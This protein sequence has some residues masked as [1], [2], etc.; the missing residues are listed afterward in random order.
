[1][2]FGNKNSKATSEITMS[3]N[4]ELFTDLFEK[5][6][7]VSRKCL[8]CAESGDFEQINFLVEQRD[9]LI[10]ITETIHERLTLEQMNMDSSIA[11]E[12]NNQVNE[13]IEKMNQMDE[14]I[15]IKLNEERDNMQIE[16]AKSFKN[17]ENFRGYN[18]N[19]LK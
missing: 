14:Q 18:L 9:K 4:Y 15:L 12:F 19:C 7:Y 1:M 13:L 8:E 17:K 3:K 5:I 6:I 11:I 16:I 2:G 10:S